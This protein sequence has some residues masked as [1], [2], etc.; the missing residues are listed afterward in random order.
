MRNTK[1]FALSLVFAIIGIIMFIFF[2]ST[3][4]PAMEHDVEVCTEPVEAVVI[5]NIKEYVSDHE[6]GSK[7]EYNQIVEYTYGNT[8]VKATLLQYKSDPVPEGSTITLWANP[9]KPSQYIKDRNIGIESYVIPIAF[10]SVLILFGIIGM[11][12]CASGVEKE[13]EF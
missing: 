3:G 11:K 5:E 12:C 13:E 6:G 8:S 4:F 2:I 9:E 1:G 10:S 7:T